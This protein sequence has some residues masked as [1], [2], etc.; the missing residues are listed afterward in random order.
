M[1]DE[2]I[3]LLMLAEEAKHQVLGIF[4]SD[5][6]VHDRDALER[7][8]GQSFVWWLFEGGTHLRWSDGKEHSDRMK[9]IS[10]T[11]TI[12]ESFNHMHLYWCDGSTIREFANI[13]ALV[14][15]WDRSFSVDLVAGL[16]YHN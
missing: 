11:L 14:E 9:V 3:Y 1:P 4:A 8:P 6:I 15:Y 5:L 10:T 2:K 16:C 7:N 12:D 13:E